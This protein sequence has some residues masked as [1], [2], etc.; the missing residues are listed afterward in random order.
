MITRE[1]AIERVELHLRGTKVGGLG[2]Q[3]AA[4]EIIQAIGAW[5]EEDKPPDLPEGWSSDRAEFSPT[6]LDLFVHFEDTQTP[7]GTQ[8]GRGFWMTS[9]NLPFLAR[10]LALAA[11]R[12]DDGEVEDMI[13]LTTARDWARTLERADLDNALRRSAV[14]ARRVKP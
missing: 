13:P 11:L 9:E 4:E 10:A 7:G 12:Q 1:E 5:A 8:V 3:E 6:T 2:S 14:R